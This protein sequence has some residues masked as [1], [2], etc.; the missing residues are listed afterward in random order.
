MVEKEKRQK[1]KTV[2]LCIIGGG[3]VYFPQFVS[4]V[5]FTNDVFGFTNLLEFIFVQSS[6]VMH[7]SL[8]DR[9]CS[10]AGIFKEAFLFYFILFVTVDY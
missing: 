10:K 9:N 7:L 2:V 5:L 8:Y 1:K 3:L 4:F 6:H